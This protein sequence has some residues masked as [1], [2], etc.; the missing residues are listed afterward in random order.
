[1]GGTQSKS[2]QF[3]NSMSSA[4]FGAVVKINQECQAEAIASNNITLEANGSLSASDKEV[5]MECVKQGRTPADCY[6]TKGN[7]NQIGTLKQESRSMV[8]AGC[9]VNSSQQSDI[10]SQM[11]QDLVSKASDETVAF[12]GSDNEQTQNI[13]VEQKLATFLS[14]DIMNKAIAKAV[15]YNALNIKGQAGLAAANV[16]QDISVYQNSDARAFADALSEN[17]NWQKIKTEMDTKVTQETKF[18]SSAMCSMVSS[19][20]VLII[21]L[22]IAFVVYKGLPS[23]QAKNSAKA[24]KG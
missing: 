4:F 20:T 7:L 14:T 24:A 10:I 2:E 21:V 16:N 23:T 17:E 5:V 11:T 12:S 8:R 3:T 13:K 15:A 18:K 22:V 1:M 19:C 9:Q 6:G